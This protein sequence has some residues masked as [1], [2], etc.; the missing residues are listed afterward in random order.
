MTAVGKVGSFFFSSTATVVDGFGDSDFL[1]NVI[2]VNLKLEFG[3]TT[4]SGV[5]AAVVVVVVVV[6]VSGGAEGLASLFFSFVS[7]S[8][9]S[10]CLVG[11]VISLYI[12][13]KSISFY[14]FSFT[15]NN[16]L[17]LNR[18]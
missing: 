1:S 2:G 8:S 13:K 17:T 15:V 4:G 10:T 3:F 16:K 14:L 6:I 11:S 18:V 9:S 12:T 7:F 5:L